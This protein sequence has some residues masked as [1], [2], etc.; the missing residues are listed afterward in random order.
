VNLAFPVTDSGTTARL[1]IM[2]GMNTNQT[3]VVELLREMHLIALKEIERLNLRIAEL[4]SQSR[5][6]I[7]TGLIKPAPHNPSPV[8]LHSSSKLP[9]A[10][11]DQQVAEY[12]N[13][14]AASLRKWRRLGGG[15]K[16]L[17]IGRAVRYRREDVETWLR[18]CPGLR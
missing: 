9:A 2:R 11:N 4:E 7:E 17:K 6:P 15:P 5:Q 14:S 1:A 13:M 8:N 10:L 12:L 3:R 16:F 18:S